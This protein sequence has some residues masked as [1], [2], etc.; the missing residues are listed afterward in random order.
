MKNMVINYV[1]LYFVCCCSYYQ[2]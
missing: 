1:G 2:Q